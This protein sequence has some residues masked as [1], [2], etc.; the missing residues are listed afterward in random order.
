MYL[1]QKLKA[2]YE[3]KAVVKKTFFIRKPINMKFK[4]GGLIEDHIN[5][6]DLLKEKVP[7]IK[8]YFLYF[9]RKDSLS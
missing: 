1:L 9:S 5:L 4:K 6:R 7:I 8:K 2:I 3:K